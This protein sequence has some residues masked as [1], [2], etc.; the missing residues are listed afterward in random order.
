MRSV[1]DRHDAI[2]YTPDVR[3]TSK[4]VVNVLRNPVTL[5]VIPDL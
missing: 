1:V 3:K 2:I 4:H 5:P